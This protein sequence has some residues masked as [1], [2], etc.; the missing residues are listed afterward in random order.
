MFGELVGAW[1]AYVHRAMDAHRS[2]SSSRS[3][4]LDAARSWPTPCGRSPPRPGCPRHPP[5]RRDEPRLR[6]AQERRLAGS[7]ATWHERPT[8]CRTAR[9]S[10]SPTSSSI[11][12]RCGSCAHPRRL[13]RTAIGLGE[14]GELVFGLAPDPAPGLKAEAPHGAVVSVPGPGLDLVPQP[15]PA[16]SAPGRRGAHLRLRTCAPR[17]RRHASGLFGPRLRRSPRRSGR[18]GPDLSRRFR[19]AGA[20]GHEVGAAVHGPSD[21]GIFSRR[22]GSTNVRRGFACGPMIVKPRRS[23]PP[24]P[25]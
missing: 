6:A 8:P 20:G 19:G 2:R 9:R 24:W 12:Y 17:L 11:A 1:V 16:G 18:G 14:D 13:A 5:S 23:M 25:A 22:S 21:Q 4:A 7:G 15:C 3:W 10:S